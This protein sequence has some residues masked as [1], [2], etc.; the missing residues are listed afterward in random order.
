MSSIV[1]EP[2]LEILPDLP[3]LFLAVIS[4]W[5]GLSLLLHAPRDR[6][7]QAFAWFC[8]NL[9][10]YGLTSLLPDLTS[11]INI[12]IVLSR[13]QLATTV[14]TPVAF[15]HFI[16]IL[17]TPTSFITTG[18]RVLIGVFYVSGVALALYALFGSISNQA[19]LFPTGPHFPE[20]LLMWGWTLQRIVP[21][22]T[23][24]ALMAVTYRRPASDEQERML[25][26]L[27][28]LA[29]L[30]GVFG[31]VAATITRNLSISPAL[32]RTVI[33]IAM[34]VLAYAV[35][36]RRALLPPRVAQRTFFYSLIGGAMTTVYVGGLLFSEE[37]VRSSL[38]I[39]TPIVTIFALVVL[40]AALGPVSDWFRSQLDRRFY[41]REF[42]YGRLMRSL[43]RDLFERGDLDD[44]LQAALST[45]CRTL[46]VKTGL[47]ALNSM[48]GLVPRATYGQPLPALHDTILP[49]EQQYLEEHLVSQRLAELIIPLRRGEENLGA[50]ALGRRRSGLVFNP[51]E[52]ALIDYLSNYLVL[53]I[54]HARSRDSHQAAMARLSEQSRAL[55]EQQ[56]QFAQQVATA[57]LQQANDDSATDNGLHVYA[58]GSL[59]VERQREA[60]N[61]WGGD[62]AGTNQAE[63]LFAFLFD[64][65]GKGV[66]KDEVAE[67]IWP[68][69]D[70]SKT[71]AAFHRTIAGLR[72]T[73]EPGLRRGNQS[74]TVL[75]HR[76]RYWLE[77]SVVTWCDVDDFSAA[78]ECGLTLFHQ[79]AH[80]DALTAL[81]RATTLY[82]GDYMDDCP[83]LGDSF[84]VENQRSAL[85]ACFVDVQLALGAI[86][87]AQGRV[88]EAMSTYRRALAASPE[89]NQPA[90]EALK[91]LSSG[92]DKTRT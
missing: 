7:S 20:G 69:Q 62:K 45:I 32:P 76:D 83:F 34:F 82:R 60:I 47:I 75:Y 28:A 77:P 55:K 25:R 84:Y 4:C 26:R 85:R 64:R 22:F 68:D 17:I 9:A 51:T 58:L 92:G 65:R 43:N 19:L 53:T 90:D 6:A 71:D 3:D 67:I 46:R 80:H 13:L 54:T 52:Q 63:A 8:A 91:R 24:L 30:I 1:V 73:L 56:E 14:I 35:L 18:R 2:M 87:Q 40:I 59:R 38:K 74:R 21:L 5:L 48:A 31:A 27:F 72:R 11:D 57:T 61:R 50:L 66:T 37:V 49:R 79:D 70:I 89:G 36:A 12:G 15:L 33:L 78:A 16:S 41:R 10:L 88:G 23:A 39:D 29:S 81:E 44:Q 42:D 86:Y